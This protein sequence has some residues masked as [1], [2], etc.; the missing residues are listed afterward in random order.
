MRKIVVVFLSVTCFV[1]FAASSLL[2]AEKA[3]AKKGPVQSVINMPAKVVEPIVKGGKT[4]GTDKSPAGKE[5]AKT[6]PVKPELVKAAEE[7][8]AK[9]EVAKTEPSKIR[10]EP[11][12]MISEIKGMLNDYV[13]ILPRIPG[14]KAEKDKAGN[15]SYTYNGIKLEDLDTETLEKLQGRMRNEVSMV[16]ID[17]TNRLTKQLKD[18]R[19]TA[20]IPRTNAGAGV[21]TPQRIPNIPKPLPRP[22]QIPRKLPK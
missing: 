4:V 18:I 22:P 2:A 21:Y 3:K 11:A 5:I 10:K 20:K 9:A 8:A 12:Q 1:F 15:I 13:E 19:D 16:K 17:R 6:E 7:T 14:L